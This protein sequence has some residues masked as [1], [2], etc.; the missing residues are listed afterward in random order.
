EA[1]LRR[2]RQLV[3]EDAHTPQHEIQLLSTPASNGS[4]GTIGERNFRPRHRREFLKQRLR[5][6]SDG[7][8]Y[9]RRKNPYHVVRAT[10]AESNPLIFGTEHEVEARVANGLPQ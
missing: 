3:E 1:L 10:Y 8:S 6:Y 5:R 9:A 4:D 2:W 7:R